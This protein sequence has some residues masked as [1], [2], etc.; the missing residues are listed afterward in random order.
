MAIICGPPTSA[1]VVGWFWIN[2]GGETMMEQQI[3]EGLQEIAERHI[4]KER[5]VWPA[6]QT[7]VAPK[8]PSQPRSRWRIVRRGWA[9]PA[10]A[11]LLLVVTAAYAV[12]PA[13]QSL[14]DADAG[15]KDVHSSGL[16]YALNQ[17]QV[18][19]GVAITLDWA[20]ADENRIAVAYTVDPVRGIQ[21]EPFAFTLTD[22]AGHQFPSTVGLVSADGSQL[23]GGVSPG[24]SG[25]V[26]SFDTSSI[27]HRPEMLD[28]HLEMSLKS[29]ATGKTVGPV[30]FRFEIPFTPGRIA[31]PQQRVTADGVTI[32]LEKVT[33]TPSALTAVICF[34]GPD[35]IYEDGYERWEPISHIDV[36]H[37][38]EQARATLGTQSYPDEAGCTTNRYFPSL[39][40]Y[41]GVWRL[42]VTE[43]LGINRG[44]TETGEPHIEQ[45]RI[46]GNWTFE[47]ALP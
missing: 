25:Y 43:L 7:K 22:E 27:T 2:I 42:T 6:L 24:E 47:F 36:I 9:L 37:D 35:D 18:V 5:D 44:F 46:S 41:D 4:G 12:A 19:N 23:S 10:L 39:Y 38:G 1:D 40:H 8:I 30:S 21:Y 11:I 16:G 17:R 28:L 3:K 29:A 31:T 45:K 20:Y 32:T 33:L 15:L 26:F 14:F 34:T 13:L